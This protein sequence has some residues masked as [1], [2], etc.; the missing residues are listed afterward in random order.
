MHVL[1]PRPLFHMSNII[2]ERKYN[3]G[4]VVT[5]IDSPSVLIHFASV[6]CIHRYQEITLETYRVVEKEQF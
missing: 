1:F 6:S 4:L 3:V 5:V 2:F